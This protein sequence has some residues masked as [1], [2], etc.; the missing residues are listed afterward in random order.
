MDTHVLLWA[1]L[2]PHL[3]SIKARDAL[4]DSA[5][6]LF[7]SAASAWEIA[8]KW[9][10]GKLTHAASVVHNYPQVLN[11]LAATEI[12]IEGRIARQAGLL[13]VEHRDPFDRLLA[14][15]AMGRELTLVSSDPAFRGFTGLALLN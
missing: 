10:L 11:S 9:R 14:A 8:T 15:Q 12:P 13:E 7:V 5:N 2:E 3:L 4:E 6:D 1:A